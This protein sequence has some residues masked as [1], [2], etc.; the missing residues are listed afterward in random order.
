MKYYRFILFIALL[1][2]S[3][4][5][6]QCSK[7]TEKM[8]IKESF[9][10]KKILDSRKEKDDFLKNDVQSP[11][12]DEDKPEFKG[13]DYFSPSNRYVVIAKFIKFDKPDTVKIFTRKP[14]DIR[15]MLRYGKF[16][17]KIGDSTCTLAGYA[18]VPLKKEIEL[19]VPFTDATSGLESYEAGRYLDIVAPDN[20]TT[21]TIDF[22]DAYSPY[23][24][25]NHTYSCPLVPAENNLSVAIKAGEKTFK[26][27]KTDVESK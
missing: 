17:F 11:L 6:I 8:E 14:E 10:P 13:L 25:Y 5:L 15:T 26:Q 18:R 4:L 27:H 20:A 19:F 21:V 16:E 7:G 24:A 22:N 9:D 2:I 23:C 1:S 3:P 12:M